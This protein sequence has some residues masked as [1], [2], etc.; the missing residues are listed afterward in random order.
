M[1][2]VLCLYGLWPNPTDEIGYSKQH[3]TD[4]FLFILRVLSVSGLVPQ[5]QPS[6]NLLLIYGVV[7]SRFEQVRFKPSAFRGLPLVADWMTLS[8]PSTE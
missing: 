1:S 5:I 4:L 7:L 3:Q 8:A 6:G 2:T